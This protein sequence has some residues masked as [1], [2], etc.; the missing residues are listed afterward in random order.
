M[1]M[2]KTIANNTVSTSALTNLLLNSM[3]LPAALSTN[4]MIAAIKSPCM[5]RPPSYLAGMLAHEVLASHA[6]FATIPIQKGWSHD[7]DE[8]LVQPSAWQVRLRG[9]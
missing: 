6:G 3:K 5:I 4:T 8:F 1:S 7:A 2:P 9:T